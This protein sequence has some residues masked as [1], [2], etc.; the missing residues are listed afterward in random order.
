MTNVVMRDPQNNVQIIR[1]NVVPGEHTLALFADSLLKLPQDYALV[2][3]FAHG[4]MQ[5]TARTS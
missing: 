2:I 4:G 1:T 3:N 5:V